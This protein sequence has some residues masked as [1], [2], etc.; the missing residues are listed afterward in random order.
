MKIF[1]TAKPGSK[2]VYVE[3]VD[4]TH[5]VVSVKEPPIQG[6]ANTA[7]IGL[8]SEYFGMRKSQIRIL[9]GYTSRQKTIKIL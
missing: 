2:E 8:L 6:R 3:K 4:D 9:S 5:F 1:V 7:I